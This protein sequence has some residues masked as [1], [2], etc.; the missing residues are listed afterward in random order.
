MLAPFVGAFIAVAL[1]QYHQQITIEAECEE[2]Q[3]HVKKMNESRSI[4][5]IDV[6][7]T[8]SL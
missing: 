8:R 6:E 7:D 5:K 3:Y 1:F 2:E 4:D